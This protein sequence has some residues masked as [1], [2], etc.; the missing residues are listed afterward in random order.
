[1]C[2]KEFDE[3]AIA[4]VIKSIETLIFRNCVIA[5]RV[6]N[7]YEV[8]FAKVALNIFDKDYTTAEEI[9]HRINKEII[10]DEEFIHAFSVFKSKK[11]VIIRYILKNINNY[12][13]NEVQVIDDNQKIHIE[14][15]MPQSKGDWPIN[16]D[17]HEEYL[18]RLGN[19]TLLGA[20]YN[21]K[22]SR[23]LFELKKICIVNQK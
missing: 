8:I 23:K 9:I 15:I 7:K 3:N 18:W 6:A 22:N 19:L 4:D 13:N 11:K 2:S 20:E 12:L 17:D 14:H 21:V 10:H 16:S 1:M 5:G